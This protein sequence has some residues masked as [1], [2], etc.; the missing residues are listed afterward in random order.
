MLTHAIGRTFVRHFEAGG[1]LL[2]FDAKKMRTY[3]KQEYGRAKHVVEDMRDQ[4][5]AA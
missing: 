2:D 4:D 3:F 5:A 1:T